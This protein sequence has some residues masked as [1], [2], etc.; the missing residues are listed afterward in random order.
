MPATPAPSAPQPQ[1]PPPLP[2]MPEI[3]PALS[4][5][6]TQFS[7]WARRGFAAQLKNNVGLPE[8]LLQ[9]ADAPSGT[10]PPVF[11]L[12][13]NRDGTLASVPVAL[14]SGATGGSVAAGGDWASAVASCLPLAGFAT[15]PP[16]AANDSAAATAGVAVGG[17][18]CNGSTLMVRQS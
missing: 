18:Y 5:Y 17:F 16:Q 10:V 12:R 11:S 6:L 3:G 1:P 4:N 7:H 14:G 2:N 9:A 13:V 15:L 8:V